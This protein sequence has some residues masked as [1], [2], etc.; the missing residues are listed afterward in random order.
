MAI[1]DY[2]RYKIRTERLSGQ[3]L[4]EG[5]LVRR[6]YS[7][8]QK[9]VRTVMAVLATGTES[10]ADTE[11]M[12]HDAPYF[13][14]A[15]LDGNA[16]RSGE[17]L[18]FVR[19]TSL[20]D[21]ARS[22]ALYLTAS[23]AAA[24]YLDVVDGAGTER[25]LCFPTMLA[26]VAEP[27]DSRKYAITGK[28]Y[29][30]ASYIGELD[31]I[32]RICR[33]Q[34]NDTPAPEG[35]T[36]G[37]C[38][39]LVDPVEHPERLLVSFRVRASQAMASIPVSLGYV[40]GMEVD[41][42]TIIDLTT[43]WTYQ[44]IVV[45][46]EYSAQHA[47]CLLIDLEG[48]PSEAWCEIAEL[49]ILRQNDAVN[50]P[51]ASKV[52]I[53]RISGVADPLFGVLD[54]YG[55]YIRNLYATRN[56]NIAGTLTAGD[57]H[58]FA[59]TFYVGRIHKNALRNSRGCDFL[60][61]TEVLAEIPPAGIGTAHRLMAGEHILSGQTEAWAMQHAGERYC[62]SFWCRSA[63]PTSVA[64]SQGDVVAGV[65][66]VDIT[67]QRR[68]VV[69]GVQ[70][71]A[72]QA[73]SIVLSAAQPIDFTSPQL[74][75]GEHPTLYQATDE[76]LRETEEYGAWFSR[77]GIGGTIQHPLLRLNEDGSISSCDGSFVINADGTGHF[78]G[79]RFRWTKDAIEL[80]GVTIRWEDFDEE[81]QEALR[82]KSV[83]ISGP[84]TFHYA[85][86]L[87]PVAEPPEIT[88]VGTEQNFSAKSR[89]WEY[90]ASSG[91]WKDAGSRNTTFL[92][93]P[94]FHVW[95]GREVLTLRYTA[96][97]QGKDYAATC[98]VDKQ[99]DGESAYSV[100]IE[101]DRGTI[102]QNGIGETTL[103]AHVMRG[104]EEVTSMIPEKQFVWTRQSVD[105]DSDARWNAVEHWG[106]TLSIGGE[107]VARKA[108]FG[109]E[110]ILKT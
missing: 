83:S 14:G 8:G 101:T 21:E 107:D 30:A 57:E 34:R 43:E 102:L 76:V 103:V 65:V 68:H 1:N 15:L 46:V 11:G 3:G 54:G 23:D 82:P 41:G 88:L 79:G 29:F 81:A 40:S 108:V 28:S 12:L 66:P 106:R 4:R 74:E 6:Q 67:W 24:P 61:P 31:G 2:K 72:G 64:L 32:R 86:A 39:C 38:Q 84:D 49:N 96:S 56:V 80:R 90:L 89:R 35:T 9:T 16:P 37:L 51:A 73:F 36:L 105:P 93:T 27:A 18:D 47:R 91:N 78:S 95:E 7:D 26:T 110:V 5:D 52:R 99:Y 17:L 19:T 53:G 45:T 58:G 44:L 42:R 22:G 25:S 20:T 70:H 71:Q 60:T 98:T 109:C 100:Y 13:V 62:F 97:Y 77:G 92:L 85:D 104:A 94:D 69:F 50:L 59:G 33:L 63:V 75:A 55:A 87:T 10:I 48:L